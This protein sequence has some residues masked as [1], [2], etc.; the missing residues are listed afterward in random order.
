MMMLMLMGMLFVSSMQP[1]FMVSSLIII[2]LMYSLYIYM[3]MGGYWFG[4]A[5]M[6]VMLSGVLVIFTYMASLSPNDSFENYNIMYMLIF[7]MMFIGSYY[8][9]MYEYKF[10]IISLMLFKS[11]FG[12]FNVFMISF[13]LMI[14]LMVV[15]LSYMMYGALRIY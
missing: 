11:F 3:N 15:W 12:L 13:L 8:I 1:M 6:M 14:M 2:I 4:Y 9:L 10:S 5:L 7:M